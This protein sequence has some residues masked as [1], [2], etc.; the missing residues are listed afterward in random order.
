MQ[1]NDRV[2][3]INSED[4]KQQTFTLEFHWRHMLCASQSPFT[5]HPQADLHFCPQVITD[6]INWNRVS[7]DLVNYSVTG[8]V[9]ALKM[10]GSTSCKS[11]S[12][13]CCRRPLGPPAEILV[14]SRVC[15][16]N[17]LQHVSE[18]WEQGTENSNEAE[19]LAWDASHPQERLACKYMQVIVNGVKEPTQMDH[20][21]W[22]VL[23][24]NI[25]SRLFLHQACQKRICLLT[26]N[27]RALEAPT[28]TTREWLWNMMLSLERRRER[29]WTE[30]KAEQLSETSSSP[31]SW[32]VRAVQLAPKKKKASSEVTV[33]EMSCQSCVSKREHV[34]RSDFPSLV[35]NYIKAHCDSR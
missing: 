16:R 14:S 6:Q 12:V 23:S 4:T 24:K 33:R 28:H 34:D 31:R 20:R 18:R 8:T 15:K 27:N 30:K 11:S 35:K 1:K 9:T 2:G 22:S 13:G 7:I 5:D 32:V 21:A 19:V 26:T 3:R 29:G 17:V 10:H 25:I